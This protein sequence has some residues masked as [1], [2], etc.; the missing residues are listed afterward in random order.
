MA[1]DQCG[2]ELHYEIKSMQMVYRS[3]GPSNQFHSLP[4]MHQ[5]RMAS[6]RRRWLLCLSQSANPGSHATWI[7]RSGGS[8]GEKVQT[9]IILI[10]YFFVINNSV[11]WIQHMPC[12]LNMLRENNN[13]TINDMNVISVLVLKLKTFTHKHE[14]KR[15][16]KDENRTLSL[17][18]LFEFIIYG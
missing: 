11:V 10:I 4:T 15:K 2:F 1:A 18:K 7:W 13:K 17:Q 8:N 16:L 5:R 14:E 3:W 9:I 6:W 12:S